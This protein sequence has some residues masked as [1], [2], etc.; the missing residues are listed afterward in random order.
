[1]GMLDG[2]VAIVTGG[3]SGIG[4]STAELFVAEGAQVVFTGRRKPEGEAI[5]K[6]IGAKA[7]FIQ[8]DATSEADLVR[9]AAV[10][11]DPRYLLQ[12]R[13][14]P[15]TIDGHPAYFRLFYAFGSV[16]FCWWNCYT[17]RYSVLTP[18]ESQRHGLEGLK[19]LV[20]QLAQ[21]TE[22]Q[23]FSTEV[24]QTAAGEF[25]LIDYIND[26]CHMLTQSANPQMGVPDEIVGGIARSLVDGAACWVKGH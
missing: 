4:E 21:L 25:V 7:T 2:K 15:R 12:E 20:C 9:S 17:D 23:F 8:A 18:E 14:V 5:A 16:W 6:R 19:K 10:W 11:K 3:T 24:A 22:M 26:Q 13:V 1:M